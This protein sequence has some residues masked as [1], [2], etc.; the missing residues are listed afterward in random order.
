MLRHLFPIVVGILV[1][2]VAA[3]ARAQSFGSVVVFGDSLSDSGNRGNL[4]R[5]TWPGLPAGSS[6]TTNPDPVAAEIVARAFGVSGEPSLAGGP[7]YAWGG[8]CMNPRGPC[9][10]AVPTVAAQIEQYLS[11]RA[12]G[13]ADPNALYSVWGGVNDIVSTVTRN[14][15]DPRQAGIDTV[16]A[17]AAAV[18]HVRRLRDA[19]ARYVVVYNLPDIGLTPFAAGQPAP[20]RGALSTL[21]GAYNRALAAGL[22]EREEGI[23][24]IDVF[25]L[26]NEVAEDPESY[27]FSDIAGTA[28]PAGSSSIACGPRDSDYRWPWTYAPGANLSHVFADARHPGGAA[29]AMVASA[30]TSTLAAPV[31]V[32]LAGEGGV[33][34]AGIHRGIVSEER[35]FDLDVDRSV[36][37]WRGWAKG[38]AGSSELDAAQGLGETRSTMQALALGANHRAGPDLYWGAALSLGRHRNDVAR[39]SLDSN[40]V[41]GSVHGMW[42]HGGLYLGVALSGGSTSVDIERSIPL[43]SAMRVERGATKAGQLGADI[44]LGWIQGEPGGLRHG[45]FLG[46]AWLDQKI[47]GYRESGNSST[48]LHFAGFDRDSLIARGGYRIAGS[49]GANTR[50]PRLHA[51]IAYERELK[52]DH[53]L[54]TAGSNRMPGRFTLPGFAAPRQWVSTDLGVTARV[55]EQTSV[56]LGHAGRFGGGSR[57]DHRLELSLRIDL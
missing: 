23:V 17:A 38:Q 53:I 33:E 56:G 24:P 52:D 11:S 39:A 25:A 7:N 31:Q 55:D 6:F 4:A 34:L 16:A 43:A 13:R 48:G 57:Q 8:A 49:L 12:G 22:R 2:G 28:C 40:A 42:R 10:S 27:G 54:V 20:V 5:Q 18:A 37:S 29:H 32:S 44:D 46:I 45:P 9:P 36:G 21:I 1:L 30:V 35:M 41:I 14:P 50:Q 51:R 26:F 15:T 19:G 47:D 3:G